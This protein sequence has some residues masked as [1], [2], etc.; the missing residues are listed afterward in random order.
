MKSVLKKAAALLTQTWLW[1]LLLVLS[2][3][4][5]VW[6][7]GPLLAVNDHKFWADP[8][9][10]L[11]SISVLILVW[12][13]AMVFV[14]WR[15]G[16]HKKAMADSEEG[17]IQAR[18]ALDAEAARKTL[19]KRFKQALHTLKNTSVYKGRSE[20]W[21]DE[22]PWYVVLG[23]QGAGKTSL[24]DF[25]GLEFPLNKLDR[26]LTR[27]LRGTRDCEWYF[28]EHG[29][30]IDTAGGYLTQGNEPVN[31]SGWKTLLG[32]LRKRKRERPLNGVLVTVPV[33]SLMQASHDRLSG[34]SDQIRAR[35]QDVHQVLRIELPV[36]LVLTKTD[37]IPGFT[38]FFEALT[39]EERAQVFGATFE[40]GQGGAALMRSEC[41]ALLVRLNSQVIARMHQERDTRRRGRMLDFP[42]Q[43]SDV[44]TQLC[45][46][47]DMTFTGNRYQ[48]ASPL[49]GF[50]LTSAP[51]VPQ[52]DE[53][54]AGV[55][56]TRAMPAMLSG[57]AYFIH[58]LLSR[59][60]FPEAQ[61]AE[62][63]KRERRRLH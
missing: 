47:A 4:L 63:D 5:L 15:A 20:R 43:L 11:L 50:Y 7:G 3:A 16:Q 53:T 40:S 6:W 41:E 58:H 60:M 30:L 21:R 29:V 31:A 61:L 9:A 38:E 10:R 37:L 19:R 59:V 32:L 27:D 39:R 8:V 14:S 22:L 52:P 25:S 62:L 49:R 54:G 24:L 28:A 45:V 18:E 13:L 48:R 44:A 17:Q 55:E 42:R 33:D 12:G 46:F 56:H 51:H 57:H 26:S 34:L 1:S 2:V 36:Y 23:P 35:L